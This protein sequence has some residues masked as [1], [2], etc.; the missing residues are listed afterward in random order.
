M[1]SVQVL[2]V[3]PH[4][5][6]LAGAAEEVYAVERAA[7]LVVDRL[8]PSARRRELVQALR[9]RCYDVLWLAT[10]GEPDGVWLNEGDLLPAGD[11]IALVRSAGLFG[12]VL[13]S[14]ESEELAEMLHD[15]T[16]VDVVCTVSAVADLTAF[17]TG[18]L[19]ARALGETGDF[20]AAFDAARP[21]GEPTFRYVPEYRESLMMSPE[22]YT[23]SN[24]ELRAIYEA[25]NDIRQR[26]SVVEIELRYVRQDLDRRKGDLR[27]PSQWWIVAVGVGIGAVLF[28]LLYLATIG[29][30]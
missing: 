14:C 10:H 17:Q 27:E 1:Q 26:L 3:A 21:G 6:E 9:G 30:V 12:V 29:R 15:A 18:A 20:R 16:G 28:V 8:P 22:R 4:M 25:I 5:P 7:G 23:F 13:N 19:F 2:L 11:L 24:E